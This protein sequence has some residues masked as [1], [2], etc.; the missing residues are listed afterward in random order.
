MPLDTVICKT[1]VWHHACSSLVLLEVY[2]CSENRL[3]SEL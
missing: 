2:P 3:R 1:A